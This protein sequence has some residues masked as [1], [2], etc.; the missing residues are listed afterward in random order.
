MHTVRSACAASGESENGERERASAADKEGERE[1]DSREVIYRKLLRSL[2]SRYKH[3]AIACMRGL[4]SCAAKE[5]VS[6][7][8]RARERLAKREAEG[9]SYLMLQEER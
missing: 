5:H 4:T 9:S 2:E 7:K 1:G 8:P 3:W 6:P